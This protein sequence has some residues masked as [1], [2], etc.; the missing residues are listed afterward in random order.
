M[1]TDDLNTLDRTTLWLWRASNLVGWGLAAAGLG[2][3]VFIIALR[4]LIPVRVPGDPFLALAVA[5]AAGGTVVGLVVGAHVY[6]SPR[7]VAAVAVML[8]SLVVVF[9]V[10]VSTNGHIWWVELAIV[11]AGPLVTCGVAAI[12]AGMRFRRRPRALRADR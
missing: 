11:I 1:K 2:F 12:V 3:L 7:L 5:V 10:P 8:P 6:R 4:T 9:G